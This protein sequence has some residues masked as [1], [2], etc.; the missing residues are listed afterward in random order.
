MHIKQN[1]HEVIIH[2]IPSHDWLNQSCRRNINM[3]RNN[4]RQKGNTRN[5]HTNQKATIE[6][7]IYI[8]FDW[9]VR[10]KLAITLQLAQRLSAQRPSA[11]ATECPAPECPAPQCPWRPF[12]NFFLLLFLL[13]RVPPSQ[14]LFGFVFIK[15]GPPFSNFIFFWFY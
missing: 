2:D 3:D 11:Q 5:P 7:F 13:R 8:Y 10:G 12:S 9:N 15:K 6:Y 1:N 4:V 14:T